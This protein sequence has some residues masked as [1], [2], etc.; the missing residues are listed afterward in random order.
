MKKEERIDGNVKKEEIFKGYM[1][2]F[3]NK[4]DIMR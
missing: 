4:E 2:E 3:E 1:I